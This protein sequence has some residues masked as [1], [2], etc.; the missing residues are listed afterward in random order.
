MMKKFFLIVALF[1]VCGFSFAQEVSS[2]KY[3]KEKSSKDYSLCLKIK[4]IY[5]L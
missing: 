3:I 5:I 1:A 2:N 4:K